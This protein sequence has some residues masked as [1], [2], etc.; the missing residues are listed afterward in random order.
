MLWCKMLHWSIS[1]LLAGSPRARRAGRC[2]SHRDGERGETQPGFA[3]PGQA[4]PLPAEA[5]DCFCLN[6]QFSAA[7]SPTGSSHLSALANGCAH[8]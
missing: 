2:Y 5:L 8:G 4:V 3:Q 6:Y 7:G 1:L